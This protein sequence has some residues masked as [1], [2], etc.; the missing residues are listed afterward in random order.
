MLTLSR[1]LELVL[2]LLSLWLPAASSPSAA[3]GLLSPAL[4]V[5]LGG[6]FFLGG[7]SFL[8]ADLLVPFCMNVA[9]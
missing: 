8:G 7:N 3:S 1:E 2:V 9:K 4:R 6:D 5:W